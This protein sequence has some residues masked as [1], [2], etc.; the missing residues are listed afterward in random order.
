MNEPT[1][2]V[3]CHIGKTVTMLQSH[4]DLCFFYLPYLIVLNVFKWMGRSR[5]DRRLSSY[6]QW[7]KLP[8]LK[9]ATLCAPVKVPPPRRFTTCYTFTC[10]GNRA[11]GVKWAEAWRRL[12]SVS[13]TERRVWTT[14]RRHPFFFAFAVS[15]TLSFS[16]LLNF[17]ATYEDRSTA[18]SFHPS[19]T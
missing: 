6:P 18:K 9:C 8:F 14:C 1:Y 3:W 15:T 17:F 2:I 16:Q 11:L 4:I 13:S 10:D 12:H 7:R 5:F 19:Q